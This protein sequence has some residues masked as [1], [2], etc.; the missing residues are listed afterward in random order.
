MQGVCLSWTVFLEKLLLGYQA[1]WFYAGLVIGSLALGSKSLAED[2]RARGIFYQSPET[3]E[4]V[5]SALPPSLKL[6]LEAPVSIVLPELRDD[7]SVPPDLPC[8][9]PRCPGIKRIA[10]THR[11]LPKNIYK[12]GGL[13]WQDTS[14]G[15]LWRLQITSVGARGLRVHFKKFNIGGGSLWIHTS[16]GQVDGPYSGRG[17]HDDG[18]FLSTLIFSD[19][20]TVEYLPDPT[21]SQTRVPFRMTQLT[22][23]LEDLN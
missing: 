21:H 10:A 13:L 22:H 9:G 16:N 19:T 20:L 23:V 18:E 6:R 2:E 4:R 7:E 8:E 1:K 17:L 5:V 11:W 15:R 3:D 12:D 14:L